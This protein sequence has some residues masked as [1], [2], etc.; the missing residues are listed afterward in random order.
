LGKTWKLHALQHAGFFLSFLPFRCSRL[1]PTFWE[2]RTYDEFQQGK[3]SNLSLTNDDRLIL[4]PRFDL[5]FD[6]QQTLIATAIADSKGNVYLGTGHDGKIYKVDPAGNGGLIADLSELDVL[7]LAVDSKDVLY[8]GASPNGKVYRIE[9]G[10]APQV[11]FDPGTKYIWSMVFDRQGR[12]IVGTGDKGV[13]YRVTPDGKGL[14]FYDTDETHIMSL[15]VDREGNIIAGGDPKGY[16]YRISPQGKAFVLYDS[17]L[18]EVHRGFAGCRRTNLC[19]SAQLPR[20]IPPL[21]TCTSRQ[22]VRPAMKKERCRSRLGRVPLLPKPLRL[23]PSRCRQKTRQAGPDVEPFRQI[24]LK[25]RFWRF[26]PTAW[27]IRF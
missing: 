25:P 26:F 15:A 10:G 19:C 16:L 1:H 27:S 2:V 8:A 4:A 7:A 21:D 14:P 5:V 20:R 24:R 13:V 18:H 11:F 3:L 6:T 17:G 9:P 22:S 12:L 23:Q